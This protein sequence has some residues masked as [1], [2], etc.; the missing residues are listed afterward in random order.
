MKKSAKKSLESISIVWRT[1]IKTQNLIFGLLQSTIFY[2]FLFSVFVIFIIFAAHRDITCIVIKGFVFFASKLRPFLVARKKIVARKKEWSD[3]LFKKCGV[4]DFVKKVGRCS[5]LEFIYREF[6]DHVAKRMW[7]LLENAT[8]N[9]TSVVNTV[10]INSDA[11][12]LL[13]F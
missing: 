13:Y 7:K 8:S 6:N 5:D 10:P 3:S 2:V 9:F 12:N 1:L 4:F 11:S